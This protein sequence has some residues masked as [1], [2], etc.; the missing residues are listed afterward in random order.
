MITE[1]IYNQK[2]ELI[3]LELINNIGY[4]LYGGIY[5]YYIKGVDG[6]LAQLGYSLPPIK[7]LRGMIEY[8]NNENINRKRI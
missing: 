3:P 6:T 7:N 1:E 2:V 8:A 4:G 5:Q